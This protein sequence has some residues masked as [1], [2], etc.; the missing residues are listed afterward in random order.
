MALS[1]GAALAQGCGGCEENRV[2]LPRVFAFAL[3]FLLTAPQ[4]AAGQD[5]GGD[6]CV[7]PPVSPST[8]IILLGAYEARALS[9]VALGPQDNEMRAGFV[10]IAPGPRPL[11]VVIATARPTIW[12]FRGAVSRLAWVV[13]TSGLTG[14]NSSRRDDGPPLAGA[15]GVAADRVR[16]LPLVDCLGYFDD[17]SS[18][19]AVGFM[20]RQLGRAPQVVAG[21]YDVSGFALPAGTVVRN[22]SGPGA[23]MPSDLE[24][25]I[26]TFYP[27]GVITFDPQSVVASQPPS[28]FDVLPGQAG[29]RQLV[30]RGALVEIADRDYRVLRKIRFPAG[31]YGAHRATFWIARG[32]PVP[33]G[34][35]GHSCVLSEA[36]RRPLFGSC[37]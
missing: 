23:P 24:R 26:A 30:Q 28:A 11:A 13:L 33:D 19:A 22:E 15:V 12:Q 35:P 8:Q 32:V 7:L 31:L 36:T 10:T 29:L 3:L 37:P 21:A 14:P 16:F 9:S 20:T 17:R 18:A 25:D 2:P 5:R 34:D 1:P 27:G 4:F 6:D